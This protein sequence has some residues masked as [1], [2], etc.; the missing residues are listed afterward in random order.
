MLNMSL[1]FPEAAW[2]EDAQAHLASLWVDTERGLQ[3]M[4][5]LLGDLHVQS[6]IGMC[7]NNFLAGPPQS[8]SSW[9]IFGPLGTGSCLHIH[10]ICELM[11]ASMRQHTHIA[12]GGQRDPRMTSHL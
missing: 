9:K 7:K 5:H 12:I 2:L 4:V 10:I 8:M 6:W 1:R 3:Q 11:L